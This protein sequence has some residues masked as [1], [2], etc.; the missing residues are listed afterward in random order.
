MVP[1][2]YHAW[3]PAS[4]LEDRTCFV[5]GVILDHGYLAVGLEDEESDE[6]WELCFSC[7]IVAFYFSDE[8]FRLEQ[9]AGGR[10]PAS[11]TFCEV[12]SSPWVSQLCDE[13]E[14]ALDGKELRHY[15]I[16]GPDGCLDVVAWQPPTVRQVAPVMVAIERGTTIRTT[17]R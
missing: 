17:S 7:G 2:D 12:P 8:S 14:G 9:F 13:A 1:L 15:G 5:V 6:C 10:L 11:G 4:D 3:R 16:Y